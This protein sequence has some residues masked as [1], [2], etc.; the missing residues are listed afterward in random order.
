MN[1]RYVVIMAGG[2]GERF[3]PQS[4]LCRPKH[5]LPIVGDE[6]MLV[7]TVNR[8]DGLVPVEN[9]FVVTNS[10]QRDA[11]LET[12]PNLLPERVVGEPEGRDTAAAVALSALLVQRENPSAAFA[13]LPAD[14]VIEDNAGF[15]TIL[16]SAFEGAETQDLLVTIG[17]RP[18]EPATGYGYIQ[19]GEPCGEP[20]GRTLY[21]AFRFVEKPDRE[22]AESYVASGDYLWNAGM[23]VWRPEVI[24]KA[25]A[26]HAPDLASGINELDD[27]WTEE[28]SLDEAMQSVYPSLTKISVDFA[29]ME[30]ADN[31][32]VLESAFDWDDVGEW[33]AIERH[34]PA[35]E[36][37]NVF[38]GA[39]L[40]LESK[41][42]VTYAEDGHMVAL[43]GVDDLIV[44]QSPDVTL[45]CRKDMAQGIKELTRKVVEAKDGE[46]LV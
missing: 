40:A 38:R 15:R 22:T 44:V 11:V 45:V 16:D 5:L 1:N 37:G 18:T 2:R 27:A 46:K 29:V 25:I 30:K 43:L 17:I 19:R 24:F 9:V 13:M 12:C 41:G 8:L 34:F 4:R 6:P 7:Q 42:N 36:M 20:G 3:W 28:A 14:H 10:E 26:S 35:D 31:V 33:P 39:G 23:F 32:A 21:N